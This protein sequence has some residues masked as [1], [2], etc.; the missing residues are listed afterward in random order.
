MRWIHI[1]ELSLEAIALFSLKLVYEK[2]GDSPILR[3]D[4]IMSGY[5]KDEFGLLVRKGDIE[6]IRLKMDGRLDLALKAFRRHRDAARA[7]ASKAGSLL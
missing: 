3:Q 5:Q 2:E 7:R 4:T 6:A 1:M